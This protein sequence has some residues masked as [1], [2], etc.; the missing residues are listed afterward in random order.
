[1]K[2]GH[3]ISKI[4]RLNI[5]L[6][7]KK[8]WSRKAH[9]LKMTKI[10]KD[11]MNNPIL[12]LKKRI[13]DKL[14]SYTK[15]LKYRALHSRLVREFGKANHCE[16]TK[17]SRKCKTYDYAL[18]N[19]KEYEFNINNFIQLCRTCHMIYDRYYKLRKDLGF[20]KPD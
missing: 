1:M 15:K 19:G 8:V 3:K 18:K 4:G 7:S 9:R 13:R 20:K 16:N 11:R 10:H 17:C 5:G 14:R 6:A 12:N 2:K